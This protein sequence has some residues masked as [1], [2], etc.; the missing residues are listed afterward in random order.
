MA[1]LDDG[2][3]PPASRNTTRQGRAIRSNLF[4]PSK[5]RPKK[6]FHCY[7]LRKY[8]DQTLLTENSKRLSRRKREKTAILAT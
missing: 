6:D 1:L 2:V 4:S 7:P 5:P 8:T 3:P